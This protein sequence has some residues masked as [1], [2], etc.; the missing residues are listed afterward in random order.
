MKFD[1]LIR[2]A[3]VYPCADG[4]LAS[5]VD[6]AIGIASGRIVYLGA[7]SELSAYEC[8]REIDGRGMFA[9]PGLCDPHTHLVY[10]GNRVD[11]FARKMAGES[12]QSIAAGGGG[13]MST[14]RA[15]RTAS[16]D[17]L[18]A[19]AKSRALAMR[20]HGVTTVE[21]KSG[22]GLT[23]EDELR[24]LRVARRLDTE[25][26]VR[27]RTTLLGAH[28]VPDEHRNNRAGYLR[29]IIDVMIPRA[30]AE[31][32]A[33]SVDVYIDEGAFTLDEARSVL[34]AAQRAGLQ[35]RAH[36]GQFRDLGGALLLAELG[37]LSADHLEQVDDAG[38]Q[39]LAEAKVVAVLL[40][41]AWRTLRQTPPD[42][43]RL[44]AHGLTMAVGTD[45]NPGTS[46]CTDI[47]LCAS[48]AVRDARLTLDEAIL[49]ITQNAAKAAG[50][51]DAGSLRIGALADIALYDGDDAR[52][53]GYVLG[54]VSAKHVVLGGAVVL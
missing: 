11:E 7:T 51:A 3:R 39:A 45:C 47:T 21:V 6:G 54:D 42:A 1:L 15:T 24:I 31:S 29:E 14:V 4:T 35:A 32:L 27:T 13:I 38:L 17:E 50:A 43:A 2:G 48:L 8:S 28:A 22:Y 49:G 41:G 12:Y 26:V 30:A 33:D 44:R 18:F 37:A 52:A 9:L 40:P 23:T 5:I 34:V 20:R 36:V 19:A 25:S 53:L 10:G 46:P 16:D